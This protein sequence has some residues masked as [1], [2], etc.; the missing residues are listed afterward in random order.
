MAGAGLDTV[1]FDNFRPDIASGFLSNC[2]SG[3]MYSNIAGGEY[4]T[5]I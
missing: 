4:I 3:N 1:F 5:T 2:K